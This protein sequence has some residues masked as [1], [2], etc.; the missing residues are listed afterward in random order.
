MMSGHGSYP[1]RMIPGHASPGRPAPNL[2]ALTLPP[3]GNWQKRLNASG[4]SCCLP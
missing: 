1:R 3:L 2:N 4:N